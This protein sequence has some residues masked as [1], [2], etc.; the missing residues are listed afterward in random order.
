LPP[1]SGRC[2]T[3]PLP[4]L[5]QGELPQLKLLKLSQSYGDSENASLL[6]GVADLTGWLS[7][8]PFDPDHNLAASWHSY[9][10]NACNTRSCWN[11]QL[12]PIAAKVA[13]RG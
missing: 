4:Q 9:N 6:R 10:F 2:H 7:H 3:A 12:A 11:S 1:A 8:E 5:G 13:Y